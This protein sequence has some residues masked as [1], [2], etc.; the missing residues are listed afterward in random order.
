MPVFI[1]IGDRHVLIVCEVPGR[2]SYWVGTWEKDEFT[3][4]SSA[5][6]RLDLFNHFLSPTPYIDEN[7]RAIAIGI[8]PETR[9]SIETWQAGWAHLYGLPRELTLDRSGR[10]QQRPIAEVC[11]KFTQLLSMEQKQPLRQDWAVFGSTGACAKIQAR[12]AHNT[13]NSVAI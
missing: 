12:I 6:Q 11:T 3:V 13:S 4:L 10:L 9:T 2:A 5:P 7:G 8:A 1:K